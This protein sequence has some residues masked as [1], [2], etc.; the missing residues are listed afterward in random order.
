MQNKLATIKTYATN[1]LK[2]GIYLAPIALCAL[3]TYGAYDLDAGAKAVFDPVKK[4]FND[5]YPTGILL[6]GGVGAF[7]QRDGD[8]RDK[9]FGFAKGAV[10]GGAVVAGVKG[11]FQYLKWKE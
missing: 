5:Y 8:L 3:D 2:W 10:A 7:L 9:M 4:M 11:V 1:T 6:S